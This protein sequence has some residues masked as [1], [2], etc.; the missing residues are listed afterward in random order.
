MTIRSDF[1]SDVDQF[2]ATL[3]EFATGSYL[4]EGETEFWEAP[5][6]A[7]ALPELKSI[8]E[9]MLDALE[10][11]PDDPDGEALATVVNASVDRL[12]AFNS[13]HEDAILEPEEWEE[14]QELI[15]AAAGATG[16]DDEALAELPSFDD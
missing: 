9:K 16:A 5:F 13:R 11:L 10:L 2:I 15:V 3:T 4:Q 8:L 12:R 14:I 1:Q 6:D 7:K